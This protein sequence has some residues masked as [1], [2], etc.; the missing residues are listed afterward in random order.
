MNIVAV[1]ECTTIVKDVTMDILKQ[2]KPKMSVKK[3]EQVSGGS[4]V[5]VKSPDV[6]GITQPSVGGES[7]FSVESLV[8]TVMAEHHRPSTQSNRW[9][10]IL[11][12]SGKDALTLG[13]N[14]EVELL[15]GN[16]LS[17]TSLL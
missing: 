8:S 11:A 4:G 2:F 15:K 12:N 6:L 7:S 13:Y 5:V 1:P 17:S 14:F 3:K 16:S 9:N 10:N